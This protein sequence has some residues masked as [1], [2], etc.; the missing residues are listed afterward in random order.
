[1]TLRSRL[2]QS[3][4]SKIKALLMAGA[5]AVA[6]VAV[7]PAFV[8]VA[9][10]Q[11]PVIHDDPFAVEASA[12]LADVSAYL[13]TGSIASFAEFGVERDALAADVATRLGLDPAAMIAAWGR[14][15]IPHQKALM[16]A[17]SQLGV[18]YHRNSSKAGVAFDCSGLTTWAWAQS[19][20]NL[21]RQSGVQIGAAAAR[22][23]DSAQAGDLAYYPGHVM[24]Y[25][26]VDTAIV[27]APYSGRTVEVAL[28]GK[29]HPRSVKFGDP[30]D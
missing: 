24:M 2:L 8:G 18:P 27:H 6:G 20:V 26:G 29:G 28:V 23:V 5:L 22:T 25:L 14:A 3:K 12:A 9:A 21:Q 17:L 1:M 11:A 10:A 13:Q 16:A 19:G 7:A 15:D 4:K 30:T